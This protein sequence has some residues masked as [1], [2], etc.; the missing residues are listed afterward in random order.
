MIDKEA[1]IDKMGRYRTQSLF[2]EM[3]YEPEAMFTLKEHNHSHAGK[4]YIS[5]KK[6][7]MEMEDPT[8]YNFA[9]TY[10]AGW[11]HWERICANKILRKHIDEWRD[12]LEQKLRAKAV[13][14]MIESADGGN[15]QAAKWLADRGWQTRAAG[16]PSKSEVDGERAKQGKIVEEYSA[17][18][19]RLYP[20]QKAS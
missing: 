19:L 4:D 18:I 13:L 14:R 17:D 10:L 12:E 2:L 6:L 5:L 15:Y 16:R 7:Y 20:E 11:K 3:D 9:T 8:E 1:M